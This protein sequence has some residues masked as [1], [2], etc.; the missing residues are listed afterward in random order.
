MVAVAIRASI[1]YPLLGAGRLWQAVGAEM[2]VRWLA[3]LMLGIP[4]LALGCV[5]PKLTG[6]YSDTGAGGGDGM[7]GSPD[8][9]GVDTG[10]E[11]GGS[12]TGLPTP[13]W[14]TVDADLTIGEGKLTALAV[15]VLVWGDD[16]SADMNCS[17]ERTVLN[18]E[19]MEL[20]PDQQIT[21]W[22]YVQTEPDSS[23]CLGAAALP[24]GFWLGL[25]AVHVDLLP[26]LARAGLEDAGG[27]YG[28]YASIPSDGEERTFC[29]GTAATA[30]V[31]GYAATPEGLAG[32]GAPTEGGALADGSYDTV[33]AWF[34]P[35]ISPELPYQFSVA[36]P[37]RPALAKTRPVSSQ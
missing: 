15:R 7:A 27:I 13:A 20:T 8:T 11:G 3:F 24:E 30:C 31:Y 35:V 33:T 34:F 5:D 9:A 6:A 12:G 25:G 2:S 36:S 22:W 10:S 21:R 4:A 32:D 28:V 18:F 17:S 29:G 26:A 19:S 37:E 23:D 14:F 16:T 1:R